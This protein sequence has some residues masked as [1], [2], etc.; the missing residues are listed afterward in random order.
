MYNNRPKA[1]TT[2]LKA[3]ILHT[4]GV[5]V[6]LR[7]EDLTAGTLEVYSRSCAKERDR[8]TRT[9]RTCQALG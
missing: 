8:Y 9:M 3:I 6:Q 2:A 4:F 7:V 1:I 5:Q